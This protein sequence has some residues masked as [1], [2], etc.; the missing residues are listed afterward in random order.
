MRAGPTEQA[1]AGKCVHDTLGDRILAR[2]PMD[3]QHAV[4]HGARRHAGGDLEASA[5]ADGPAAAWPAGGSA[6]IS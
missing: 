6:S 1:D 3:A 4:P 5:G 2:G